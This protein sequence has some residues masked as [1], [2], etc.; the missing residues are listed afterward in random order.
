MPQKKHEALNKCNLDQDVAE[1]NGDEIK[2]RK[3]R[4]AASFEGQ[5][6]NQK[7]QHG[8]PRDNKDHK[9]NQHSQVYLPIDSLVRA[10]AGDNLSDLEREEEERRVVADGSHVEGITVRKTVRIIARD[11]V[12]KRIAPSNVRI[13]REVERF[14]FG[15]LRKVILH[16]GFF[17]RGKR[18]FLGQHNHGNSI[19]I[20]RAL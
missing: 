10:A 6:Q 1:A 5:R 12:A 2:Q 4:L 19:F 9:Q 13:R 7:A 14:E 20:E 16:C 17:L 8:H 15:I 11:Q 3:R 18:S